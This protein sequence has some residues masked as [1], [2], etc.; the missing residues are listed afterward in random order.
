[1]QYGF[2]IPTRGPL[3]KPDDIAA[4]AR[5][6]EAL[7]F[8]YVLVPDHIVIPRSIDSRYPYS[9]TGAFPGAAFPECLDQLS[10]MAFLAAATSKIR[11]LTSVMVVPHRNP[12]LTAK[13]LAT[14]DVLSKGRVTVGCGAGWMKEEFEA[15]GVPPFEERGKVTDEYIAVFKE[16]WSNDDPAFDGAYAKFSNISALPQPVQRP[17]PP[18]WI[19][20]ESK[21]A[22]RRAARVGDA[23]Y[24]IGANPR[25]PLDTPARFEARLDELKQCAEEI[26]RDPA[27]IDVVYWAN[28]YD[29]TATHQTDTGERHLLTGPADAVIGDIETL[30]GMGVSGVF[31]ALQGDTVAQSTDRMDRFKADVMDKVQA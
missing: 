31:V 15:I 27:G 7:G 11:M 21:P 29:E 10:T 9:A 24:P 23:W 25:F 19:G 5:H 22:L 14:I 1:M 30:K 13:M 2:N 3:A 20:G 12:V 6:G 16:I 18:I 8:D 17:G 28:W 4:I 26:D